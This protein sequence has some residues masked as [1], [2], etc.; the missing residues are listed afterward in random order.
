MSKT[1]TAAANLFATS[2]RPG[3]WIAYESH[4]VPGGH[5]MAV[6]SRRTKSAALRDAAA[7]VAARGGSM[8]KSERSVVGGL[9]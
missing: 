9:S 1:T 5:P 3:E 8:F 7:Y 2:T 4:P 6:L